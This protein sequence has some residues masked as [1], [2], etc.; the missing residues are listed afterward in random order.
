[1]AGPASHHKRKADELSS[2]SLSLSLATNVPPSTMLTSP[3]TQL[4]DEVAAVAAATVAG[5]GDP[6]DFDDDVSKEGEDGD[7]DGKG[8]RR[9]FPRVKHLLTPDF[10]PVSVMILNVVVA[11]VAAVI[12]ACTE[13]LSLTHIIITLFDASILPCFHD[14]QFLMG[15]LDTLD[16]TEAPKAAAASHKESN[17]WYKA[18]HAIYAGVGRECSQPAGKNRYHKFKDKIV[19][20]WTAIEAY[21]GGDLP[22]R[23]RA[24]EQLDEHR[25]ACQNHPTMKR[26][27]EP[28]A[29]A[30][31]S[32]A[33]A[34]LAMKM[35]FRSKPGVKP[36]THT[37]WE[38]LDE[39]AALASLPGDLRNLVHCRNLATELGIT[40]TRSS[41]EEQYEKALTQYLHMTPEEGEGGEDALYSKCA[42]LA[43]LARYCHTNKEKREITEVFERVLTEYLATLSGASLTTA[44]V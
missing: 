8:A 5:G 36:P 26:G 25:R 22:L 19:E 15:L 44:S 40:T 4:V 38:H 29:S 30:S 1:M 21:T 35:A 6:D 9:F 10:E 24:L 34:A 13:S 11:A 28:K 42:G 31:S 43:L 37:R 3:T 7:G 27:G 23:G 20:L 41:M 12:V 33:A 39:K 17:E 18:F 14:F 16:E 2:S 32:A